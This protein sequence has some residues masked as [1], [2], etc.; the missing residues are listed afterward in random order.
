MF[1]LLT[2]AEIERI[3][4]FGTPRRYAHGELHHGR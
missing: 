4:R 3:R 1:P 2:D